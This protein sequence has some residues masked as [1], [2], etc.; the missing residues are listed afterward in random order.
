MI[1]AYVGGYDPAYPRNAVLRAGLSRLG[2]VLHP[3]F[4]PKRAGLVG[5]GAAIVAAVAR[6]DPAPDVV[7]VAEFC[8]KDVP[9]AWLAARRANA[10]L[11]ADPLIS[12]ADTLVGEWGKYKPGSIEAWTNRKWDRIAMRWPAVV[13]ADTEVH[14]R[15]FAGAADRVPFPVVYVGAGDDYFD[16]PDVEPPAGPFTALYAGG[17][18]PLHGIGTIL[19]AAQRL[20]ARGSEVVIELVGDGIQYKEAR[21]RAEALGLSNVRFAGRRPIEELPARMF[22]AHAV[23][24]VFGE[25]GEAARV[26][27]NKVSQGLASGRCVVT[28]D[29]E[30]AR[31]LLTHGGDAVLVPPGDPDALADALRMLAADSAL[32]NRIAGAGRA[33]ARR[34]LTPEAVARQLLVALGARKIA[35]AQP[36]ARTARVA[37]AT[38]ALA[39]PVPISPAGA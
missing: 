34:A 9:A 15:R 36:A 10:V 16:L 7:L 18:L 11:A 8:H 12:R 17:F 30:A 3:L 21:A 19:G 14:A 1:L 25:T 2:I 20:A 24:G 6:L 39:P 31:E 23:L 13:V 26:I 28:G 27:P 35:Q 37:A 4:V 29:T 33:L 22:N 32:R 38:P 5:R